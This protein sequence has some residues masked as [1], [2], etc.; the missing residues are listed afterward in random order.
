VANT[1]TAFG[2][3]GL[4]EPYVH[5][6]DAYLRALEWAGEDMDGLPEDASLEDLKERLSEIVEQTGEPIA[7]RV[8]Y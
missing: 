6:R 4:N 1:F 5:E 3:D 8:T 2:P 7:V